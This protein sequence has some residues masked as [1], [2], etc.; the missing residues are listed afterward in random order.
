MFHAILLLILGLSV[1]VHGFITL[2]RELS[3][4]RDLIPSTEELLNG[5]GWFYLTGASLFFQFVFRG[6]QFAPEYFVQA[7]LVSSGIHSLFQLLLSKTEKPLIGYK[8]CSVA[9]VS[10]LLVF[11]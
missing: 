8:A 6:Q 4:K 1:L 9:V 5:N 2:K 11:I 10:F 7:F 3:A